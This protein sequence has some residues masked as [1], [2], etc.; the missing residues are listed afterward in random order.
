MQEGYL[1]ELGSYNTRFASSWVSGSPE[2]SFLT[3]TKVKGKEQYTIQSYRCLSCGY[4]ESY[5][6]STKEPDA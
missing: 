4:L 6:R 5:A 2:K 1:L 3:G